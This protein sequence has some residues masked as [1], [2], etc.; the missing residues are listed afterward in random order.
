[1]LSP[2]WRG[3]PVATLAQVELAAGRQMRW[4][5][6]Q[7][8]VEDGLD[9]PREH[10]ARAAI[11]DPPS[12]FADPLQS[13]LASTIAFVASHQHE[14]SEI[15]RKRLEILRA[16]SDELASETEQLEQRFAG[17]AYKH[18][19]L[20]YHVA[21]MEWLQ[22]EVGIEDRD[23][24]RLLLT[25]LPVV[26]D[27][28]KS[29]FFE[30]EPCPAVMAVSH[31]LMG[32][33]ARRERL[34]SKALSFR[35][36][37]VAALE[38]TVEKTQREIAMRTMSPP[39]SPKELTE[40]HGSLWNVV[41]RF[42]IKQGED[43][44]GSPKYRAIDDHSECDNN[45]AA[46]RAQRVPMTGVASLMVA[47]KTLHQQLQERDTPK[48]LV[49][50]TQDMKSAY[51]QIPISDSSLSVCITMVTHPGS[52][53]VTYHELYGQPFGASHA[54]PNFCRVAEWLSRAGRRWLHLI[55][56]HFFDDYRL[57]DAEETAEFADECLCELFNLLGFVLDPEKAQRPS[58]LVTV[59]G[60]Q[61][62][63][64][65][66]LNGELKVRPKPERV[67]ALVQEFG[68][69][70]ESECLPPA[71]AAHLVGR[72]DFVNSTLFGRVGR[73]ALAVLRHR[74][75][76]HSRDWSL[77]PALKEALMWLT[78]LFQVAPA[79]RLRLECNKSSPFLVY[80]DGS[81]ER[82][83][84]GV[85]VHLHELRSWG[86]G[87]RFLVGAFVWHPRDGVKRYTAAEV[88][89]EVVESWIPKK[90]QIGQV[91]LFGAVLGLVTFCS[92]LRDKDAIHFIDNDS[93]TGA[94][95]RG[96]SGKLDSARLVSDYW[97]I[98]AR[99]Q[100]NSP[101]Y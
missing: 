80:S 75:H 13:D 57:L 101:L 42:G 5:R 87:Q 94:I 32:A 14:L 30:E 90:Q 22:D 70:L 89:R 50:S 47:A 19:K 95:V 79:R 40:R 8:L 52:N 82:I 28:L 2:P 3:R 23:V 48:Q 33:P 81:A 88:P 20:R 27:Q 93:A 64:T 4:R 16:K 72:A 59:L 83:S 76:Q 44:K 9:D 92:L 24:P 38:A 97:M 98:A 11:L 86:L 1:M 31:L 55:L 56:D 96:Y 15:R 29:A 12:M 99:N 21:L 77:S 62:D 10:M 35:P 49:V 68:A 63:L 18:M 84:D 69:I 43:S 46:A 67:S 34:R 71:Q 26:G 91:E 58:R 45:K 36:R 7:Q 61:F 66:Q 17:K 54:V 100:M 37:E 39:L 6:G 73:A 51:R 41:R 74:Q 85:R 60:V 65:Q 53:S 25:G 78:E